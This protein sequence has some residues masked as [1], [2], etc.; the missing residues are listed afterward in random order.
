MYHYQ[1]DSCF[2]KL[3]AFH[4][5]VVPLKSG[6]NNIPEKSI[7]HIFHFGLFLLGLPC[8]KSNKGE[9]THILGTIIL[10][11][12][13]FVIKRNKHKSN[14]IFMLFLANNI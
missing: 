10:K 12:S 3:F 4:G 1:Q 5:R 13:A 6:K 2:D 14:K 7:E 8:S 9:R 11:T